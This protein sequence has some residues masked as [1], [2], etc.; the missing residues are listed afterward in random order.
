MCLADTQDPRARLSWRTVTGR[1]R[2][3]GDTAPTDAEIVEATLE[4]AYL[5]LCGSAASR[6]EVSAS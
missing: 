3:L 6:S 5:L 1:Y 2:N 4:D